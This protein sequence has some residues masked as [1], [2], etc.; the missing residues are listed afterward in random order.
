MNLQVT[1]YKEIFNFQIEMIEKDVSFIHDY[2][3]ICREHL[4]VGH[5]T[6]NLIWS[7]EYSSET[8]LKV[9]SSRFRFSY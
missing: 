6:Y 1:F 5:A 4:S 9:W 8:C 7:W 3:K 2:K